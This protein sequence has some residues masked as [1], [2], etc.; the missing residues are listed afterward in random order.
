MSHTTSI[1]STLQVVSVL[2]WKLSLSRRSHSHL[3]LSSFDL[4]QNSKQSSKRSLFFS[5]RWFTYSLI[6]RRDTDVN[7]FANSLCQFD[8][9]I[10]D[11]RIRI[12]SKFDFNVAVRLLFM[13][14]QIIDHDSSDEHFILKFWE[15][16]WDSMSRCLSLS[17]LRKRLTFTWARWSQRFIIIN[18][19][20]WMICKWRKVSMLF[21]L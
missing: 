4:D 10:K 14:R 18:S 3:F 7:V 13:Q 6:S 5:E 8:I 16:F 21:C 17:F 9:K 19:M 2:L 20:T 1:Q 15:N 12:D 11:S